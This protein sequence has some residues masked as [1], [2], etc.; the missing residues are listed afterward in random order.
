MTFLGH[1]VS[2]AGI[3]MD[4]KKLEA[5]RDWPTPRNLKETRGFIGLCAYYRKFIR[6]F[7]ETAKPLHALTR[8]IEPFVWSE[9]CQTA[10]DEL[11]VK[12][13]T[14]P[15]MSLPRDEGEYILDTDA[16]GWAIGAVLSQ[17]QDSEERTLSYGS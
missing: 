11:K 16:S 17:V 1:V 13:T 8:K 4:L 10:F 7:S 9:Q 12:L 15:V 2:E 3:A 6:S 5:V 14:A